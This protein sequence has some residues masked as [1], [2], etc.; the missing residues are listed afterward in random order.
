MFMASSLEEQR[1]KK[2]WGTT[3]HSNPPEEQLLSN[4]GGKPSS[5]WVVFEQ[6]DSVLTE[7]LK[8]YQPAGRKQ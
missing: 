8:S 7:P 3:D 4:L 6:K 1:C 5:I 2:V